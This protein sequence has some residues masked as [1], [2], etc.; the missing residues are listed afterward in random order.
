MQMPQGYQ[1]LSDKVLFISSTLTSG[2]TSDDIKVSKLHKLQCVLS[3]RR[4]Y[5]ILKKGVTTLATVALDNPQVSSK[6]GISN[7]ASCE[8]VFVNNCSGEKFV[9]VIIFM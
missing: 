3:G 1:C 8:S 6:N 4:D 7:T 5:I 2:T 9:S